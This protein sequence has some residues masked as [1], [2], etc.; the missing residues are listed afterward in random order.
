ME[1]VDR[2]NSQYIEFSKLFSGLQDYNNGQ[3]HDELVEIYYQKIS[4][5]IDLLNESLKSLFE[6]NEDIMLNKEGDLRSSSNHQYILL[7]L[8]HLEER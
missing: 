6:L 3:N 7:Y 5:Q 1:L 8:Y 4:P 2:I